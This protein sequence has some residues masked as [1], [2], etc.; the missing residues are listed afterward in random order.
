M[1]PV[2]GNGLEVRPD[3]ETSGHPCPYLVKHCT[4]AALQ[5]ALRPPSGLEW[6]LG[7]KFFL[8]VSSPAA[9][10]RLNGLY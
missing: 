7:G 6:S 9:G 8:F 10:R 3:Q 1:S 4:M 2:V 5:K